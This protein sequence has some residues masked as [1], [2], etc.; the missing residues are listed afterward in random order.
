MIAYIMLQVTEKASMKTLLKNKD[1]PGEYKKCLELLQ[2]AQQKQPFSTGSRRRARDIKQSWHLRHGPEN[3][4]Q[5]A[6]FA[7]TR[8]VLFELIYQGLSLIHI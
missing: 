5:T 8:R 2:M 1:V 7:D 4:W 6:N 3:G